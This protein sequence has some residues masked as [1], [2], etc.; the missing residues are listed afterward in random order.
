MAIIQGHAKSSGVTAFYPKT[1]DQSLRFEDGNSAYL[2]FD[3]AAD[4]DKDNWSLSFWFKRANLGLTQLLFGQGTNGSNNRDIVYIAADDTLEVASYGGS[5]VF[6]YITTQKFRDPSAWYH[7]VISY[8]SGDATASDRLRIYLNGE[9]ITAFS[10]STDPALNADSAHFN[11]GS[12]QYFGRY[13]DQSGSYL[14]GY[15]AEAHFT[16]GTAYDA[17]TFGELKSGIWVPKEVSVTYGTNGFYLDFADGAAIGDDE[18]G[19]TNDFTVNNLVASDVVPDSPT[20][21]FCTL[22]SVN[23]ESVAVFAEGNLKYNQTTNVLDTSFATMGMPP[24]SGKW[25]WEVYVLSGNRGTLGLSDTEQNTTLDQPGGTGD[26]GLGLTGAINNVYVGEDSPPQTAS[27]SFTTGDYVNICYDSD[28]GKMWFGINGTWVDSGDPDTDSNEAPKALSSVTF[29]P[30]ASAYL[31]TFIF[32]FGQDSTFA[33]NTTAGG[34]SDANGIGDFKYT[35]PTDAKALCTVNL[36]DPVIDPAQDATPEDHFNVALYT[37]A[38]AL[39]VDTGLPSVDMV[40]IKSRSAAY[41]PRIFDSIRGDDTAI[42]TAVAVAEGS[43][44]VNDDCELNTPTDGNLYFDVTNAGTNGSGVSTV[45]W[46]WKA[47]GTGVSNTDGSITSTVSA[48]PDAGFSIVSYTGTGSAATVGHGL[49]SAPEMVI[50]KSRTNA[51]G[52]SVYHKGVASDAE[53]DYLWLNLNDA[54]V[55]N[56]AFWNDTAPTSSVFSVGTHVSANRSGANIIAYCFHS[57]D[58]FSKVGSYTGNGSATNG[59]FVYTGFR[60]K[61]IMVKRSDSGVATADWYIW[62]AERNTFNVAGKTVQ[63]NES[64]A[65]SDSGNHDLDILSNGFKL[66]IDY[67]T[68]NGSGNNFIYLA[69]AEQPFKYSNAR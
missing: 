38:S 25:Y 42:Y 5:Y 68:V 10:T 66:R 30:S 53:T 47:G 39:T 7:L 41:L 49:S 33:G 31:S 54:A 34:N 69:F 63:A 57:V 15:L 40:W 45:A 29:V 16:D 20:N 36:P 32:N 44:S 6:R 52:W 58:G 43:Y 62:D 61:W 3:P 12:P 48:N 11:S 51:D 9:R 23:K 64:T 24:N 13:I 28:N 14:D 65:E 26:L 8:Q 22:N 37:G 46:A 56:S 21:N 35:V 60:P 55:D 67:A 18:S 19:N 59:T 27:D 1:I 2:T 50:C 4:G 17:D